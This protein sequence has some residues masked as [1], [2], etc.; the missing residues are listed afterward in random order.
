MLL[1]SG[2]YWTKTSYFHSL[3]YHFYLTQWSEIPYSSA[4]QYGSQFIQQKL[5][6]TTTDEKNVVYEEIMPLAL[7]MMTDV[8]GNYVNQKVPYIHAFLLVMVFMDSACEINCVFACSFWS[9]GFHRREENWLA[10]FS[11]MF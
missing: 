4:E 9:T 10:S 11:V 7:V 5:Q 8:F 6:T 1:S 3:S 2:I